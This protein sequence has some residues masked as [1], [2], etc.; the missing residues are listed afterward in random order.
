MM[1]K[2]IEYPDKELQSPEVFLLPCVRERSCSNLPELHIGKEKGHV[3]NGNWKNCQDL[4]KS[5]IWQHPA[6]FVYSQPALIFKILSFA[7]EVEEGKVDLI[8]FESKKRKPSWFSFTFFLFQGLYVICSSLVLRG[9]ER[10]LCFKTLPLYHSILC[11]L[12]Q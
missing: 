10:D 1:T 12:R 5:N 9:R 2:V 7:F 3:S 11:F 8:R 4:H 6:S